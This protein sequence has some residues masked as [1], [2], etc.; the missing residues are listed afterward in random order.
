MTIYSN[1]RKQIMATIGPTFETKDSFIAAMDNDCT[2]F[3]L[4]FGYRERNHILHASL[5]REAEKIKNI[6]INIIADLPSARPRIGSIEDYN[7]SEGCIFSIGVNENDRIF[8]NNLHKIMG[9]INVGEH[10]KFLDGRISCKIICI[11]N[12]SIQLLVE[13]GNG[14]LK[15][16]NS[17]VFVDSKVLYTPI[18]DEDIS[19]LRKIEEN[20]TPLDWIAL[21]MVSSCEDI[22]NVKT[23]LSKILKKLPKIM[24]KIEV[25][26]A[27]ENLQSIIEESDGVM[28]A[29]GDLGQT[30]PYEDLPN[31]EKNIISISKQLGKPVFVATQS[32]EVFAETGLPQKAELID[33]AAVTWLDGDGI[34]LGKETVWSKHPIES[35]KLASKVMNT[36]NSLELDW[37]E[38]AKIRQ[39]NFI[40]IEGPDGVGKTTICN[41]LKD[42]GFS[43]LRG[44]PIEWEN[45]AL[46]EKMI[47]SQSWISSAMYF[48]S[49][50]IENSYNIYENSLKEV[51]ISDRCVWSSFV[52]HYKKNPDLLPDICKLLSITDS[53]IYFPKKVF[54]LDAGFENVQ[55]RI[56]QKSKEG[57]QLDFLLPQERKVYEREIMFFSWLKEL[58]LPIEIIDASKSSEEI[59]KNIL[60]KIGE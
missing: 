55:Y 14:T 35:I 21:S 23:T 38:K 50:V 3:R 43:I 39:Q 52:V 20:N 32:L 37:I 45:Q 46:K 13:S 9:F 29:R 30:V 27:I 12:G 40:A 2:W 17:V 36:T 24:A 34:M 60:Y 15:T 49:G 31:I 10:V 33:L 41:L 4:P 47:A 19:L 18:T 5:I 42:K 26:Q 59:L 8:V 22:K 58:G 51:L 28:V 25:K 53:Y 54:V 11:E 7:I 16:G 48:L 57:R 6:K 56:S 1:K 44:I